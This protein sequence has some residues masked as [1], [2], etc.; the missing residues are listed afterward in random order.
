MPQVR[1]RGALSN[2]RRARVKKNQQDPK[3]APLQNEEPPK[4]MGKQRVSASSPSIRTLFL[5]CDNDSLI[6]IDSSVIVTVPVPILK[7]CSQSLTKIRRRQHRKLF[8]DVSH[9]EKNRRR[10]SLLLSRCFSRP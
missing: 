7:F 3:P 4:E 9:K 6:K 8:S 1:R 5:N 10:P 2:E